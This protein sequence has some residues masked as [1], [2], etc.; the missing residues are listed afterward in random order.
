MVITGI[1]LSFV[2]KCFFQK[3]A[4][5]QNLFDPLFK[6]GNCIFRAPPEVPLTVTAFGEIFY[7]LYTEQKI[8]PVGCGTFA[9]PEFFTDLIKAVCLLVRNNEQGK[10]PRSRRWE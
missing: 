3:A 9:E 5:P 4:Q 10:Y 8:N 1:M 7:F 6:M 2:F